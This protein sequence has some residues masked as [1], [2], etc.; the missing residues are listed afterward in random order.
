MPYLHWTM[1]M[2][3]CML[4]WQ[5]NDSLE[6]RVV[7]TPQSPAG[8]S[9]IL[10]II[11]LV[12][13]F[14]VSDFWRCTMEHRLKFTRDAQNGG[15]FYLHRSPSISPHSI[16]PLQQ[17]H[18]VPRSVHLLFLPI[19]TAVE[20]R[21]IPKICSRRRARREA[22]HVA[23]RGRIRR[24]RA[25]PAR[26]LRA[27]RSSGGTLLLWIQGLIGNLRVPREP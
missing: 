26:I 4:L 8:R 20:P 12:N 5:S 2:V 6:L 10:E 19:P 7:C 27:S 24:A 23:Q 17:P 3:C 15:A 22:D 16:H 9:Y 13:A 14:A 1:L 11:W 18:G 21:P 25:P